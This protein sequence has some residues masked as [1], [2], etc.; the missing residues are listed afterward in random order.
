MY[1]RFIFLIL[2]LFVNTSLLAFEGFYE[3]RK[4]TPPKTTTDGGS[5]FGTE[6]GVSRDI[7]N[8]STDEYEN[9]VEVAERERERETAL[10]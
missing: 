2:S 3:I 1:K 6:G 8:K 4:Y 10:I 9:I 7:T 5:Y